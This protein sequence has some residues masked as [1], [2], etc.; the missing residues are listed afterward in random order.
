MQ[1]PVLVGTAKAV[2]K[3]LRKTFPWERQ[4]ALCSMKTLVC[5]EIDRLVDPI[6]RYATRK[7]VKMIYMLWLSTV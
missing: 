4:D 1:S 6:G 7:Q 5:D 3:A 2:Q